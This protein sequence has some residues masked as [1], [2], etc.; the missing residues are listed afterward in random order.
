MEQ[1]AAEER[2]RLDRETA[3]QAGERAASS[4][5]DLYELSESTPPW[6]TD[7]TTEQEKNIIA[8]AQTFVT[9][10]PAYMTRMEDDTILK[11]PETEHTE[12]EKQ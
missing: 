10:D 7:M 2:K 3:M 5:E 9:S 1:E 11:M 4:K 12:P 6:Q 8:W